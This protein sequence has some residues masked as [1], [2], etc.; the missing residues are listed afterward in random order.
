MNKNR[1]MN[2]DLIIIYDVLVNTYEHA[3]LEE[4][5]DLIID[6]HVI[7]DELREKVKNMLKAWSKGAYVKYCTMPGTSGEDF[8]HSFVDEN[9]R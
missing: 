8:L 3:T 1:K 7:S 4:L 9:L 5:E 6:V 2:L